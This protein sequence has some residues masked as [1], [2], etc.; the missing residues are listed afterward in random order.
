MKLEL[1]DEHQIPSGGVSGGP[2]EAPPS[3]G[4]LLDGLR[5]VGRR[6]ERTTTRAVPDVAVADG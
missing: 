2:P 5:P 6:W 3:L 4:R 1:S